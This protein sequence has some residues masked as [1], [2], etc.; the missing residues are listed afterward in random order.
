MKRWRWAWGVVCLALSPVWLDG[1]F[2]ARAQTAGADEEQHIPAEELKQE[3]KTRLLALRN[4]A[5]MTPEDRAL[6]QKAAESITYR[7]TWKKYQERIPPDQ[8]TLSHGVSVY[9]MLQH[10]L[11]PF[12][13]TVPDP[14]GRAISDNQK[15]YAEEF[16]RAFN[17]PVRKVLSNP[18]PIA[19]INAGLIVARLSESGAESLADLAAGILD[20]PK[21]LDAVKHCALVGLKNIFRIKN[22][23]DGDPFLDKDLEARC[24]QAMDNFLTRKP[25]LAPDA[26][27]AEVEGFR[28]VRREAVRA[29]GHTRFPAIVTKK[30]FVA[31]P[32]LDILRILRKDGVQPEPNLSEQVEACVALCRLKSREV[33]AY[34]PVYAAYHI[35]HF[36]LDF[37][38]RYEQERSMPHRSLSW[39][40]EST[41]LIQALEA[42][43]DD[44]AGAEDADKIKL[45]ASRGI[46]LLKNIQAGS[47]VTELTQ[48]R[49]R[50][51][52]FAPSDGLFR[53]QADSAIKGPEGS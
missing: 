29:L 12:I 31:R 22:A 44:T 3:V 19:R 20:D 41:R 52:Q 28:Y 46:A 40:Y 32:A 23:P 45:L 27:Q 17:A 34:R 42:F 43:R 2:P 36:L 50:L 11:F 26:S 37:G 1:S 4:G 10:D 9:D 30:I 47:P 7:V 49:A 53:G 6:L 33:S 35:G 38:D 24:I 13:V 18:V 14:N 16:A 21:Q 15:N 48:M 51:A 39:K 25:A 5:A 8:V